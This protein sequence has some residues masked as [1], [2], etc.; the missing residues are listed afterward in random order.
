MGACILSTA[1]MEGNASK[2]L[3]QNM[4]AELRQRTIRFFRRIYLEGIEAQEMDFPTLPG[5]LFPV[6]III[7]IDTQNLQVFVILGSHA[8]AK[9]TR[10]FLAITAATMMCTLL[11]QNVNG[12]RRENITIRS[13]QK[14]QMLV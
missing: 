1:L 13:G 11:M 3:P 12:V 6:A 5:V 9:Q 10:A 8:Y 14:A 7:L 4:S 2:Q